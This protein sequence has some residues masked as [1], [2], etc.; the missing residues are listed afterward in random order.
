MKPV[1]YAR[2]LSEALNCSYSKA[3]SLVE[4]VRYK[5]S[6]TGIPTEYILTEIERGVMHG[7]SFY[8]AFMKS[9]VRHEL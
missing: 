3:L 1:E 7:D 9:I 4:N 6:V 5:S 2:K 8:D